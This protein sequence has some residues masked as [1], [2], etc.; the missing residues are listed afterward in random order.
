LNNVNRIA[1]ILY[2]SLNQFTF[3]EMGF[4][5]SCQTTGYGRKKDF[6]AGKPAAHY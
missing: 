3:P 4:L 2:S 5:K 1:N 6:G